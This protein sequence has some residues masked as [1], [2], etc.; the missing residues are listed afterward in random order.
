MK[1]LLALIGLTVVLVG[2]VGWK[3]GWYDPTLQQGADGHTTVKFDVNA[4]KAVGDVTTGGKEAVDFIS[5]QTKGTSSTPPTSTPEKKVEG[6]STGFILP[7]IE[8]N[9]GK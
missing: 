1:N 8:I 5:N 3:L 2:G 4:K 9:V 7:K 6:Q